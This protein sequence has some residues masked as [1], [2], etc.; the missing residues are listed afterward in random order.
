MNK[1]RVVYGIGMVKPGGDWLL[2]E[3]S[4]RFTNGLITVL[5]GCRMTPGCASLLLLPASNPNPSYYMSFPVRTT[6]M[7]TSIGSPVF[8]AC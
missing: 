1:Y 8:L 5:P 4:P 3:G 6:F 7:S 2:V